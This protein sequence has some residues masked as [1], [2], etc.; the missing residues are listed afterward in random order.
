MVDWA[1]EVI[2]ERQMKV[3]LFITVKFGQVE[4]KEI[5]AL[6]SVTTKAFNN[7]GN[8]K[9]SLTKGVISVFIA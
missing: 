4:K 8:C 9:R 5:I 1:I 2:D 3:Y 6:N 7:Q